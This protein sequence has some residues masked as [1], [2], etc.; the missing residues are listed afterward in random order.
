MQGPDP[1]RPPQP[2]GATDAWPQGG[3]ARDEPRDSTRTI[4]SGTGSGHSGR[5]R[6]AVAT[7]PGAG[8]RLDFFELQRPIGAGGM[9]AVF[10]ALDVRLD[11]FIALK[12]LPP[13]QAVDPEVVQR[14]YQ[15]ARA[16]A[17]L[18]H[19]NIARVYTIGHD[20]SYHFIAFEFIE[21]TTLRDRVERHGPLGITEAIDLTL[22]IAEALMHASD[23]GVVHRDI[24]PSN[25]VVTPQ[26]RAK[27]VDMGLARRFERGGDDGLTQS[28][29]TLG[30]FDYISPEQA[31]DPR[32]VDVRSD[33]YSL[34]CTLFHV[35]TGRPP[36]PEGTVIQKLLQH[37]ADDPPDVRELNPAIPDALAAIIGKLMAKDRDR[38]HQSPEQLSRELL[39]AAGTL[40][41][42]P[43]HP[44]ALAWSTAPAPSRDWQRHL[45]WGLPAVALASIVAALVWWSPDPAPPDGSFD[46]VPSPRPPITVAPAPALT[47]A[48]PPVAVVEP[49]AAPREI[50]L[51]ARD[52]LAE[53]L[54]T[55]PSGS[56]L[57]L[58]EEA[59]YD[60]RPAPAGAP[61]V[62]AVP[63]GRRDLTIKAGPGVRPV[64]RSSGGRPALLDFGPGRVQVEGLAFAP[65]PGDHGEPVAALRARDTDLALTRCT[66]TR[67]LPSGTAPK[68]GAASPIALDLRAA[69]LVPVA[70]DPV[71][72]VRAVACAF[73][74]GQVGVSARG[75]VRASFLDCSFAGADPAFA[76]ASAATKPG[77]SP[78]PAELD[79]SF[80]T[81][82]AGG[83]PAFRFSGVAPIVKVDNSALAPAGAA[84]GTLVAAD[85]PGRLDWWGRHNL[86]GRFATYLQPARDVPGGAPP[87]RDFETWSNDPAGPRESGSLATLD[88][89]WAEAEPLPG[90]DAKDLTPALRLA[91]LDR[92]D[93]PPGARVGP[94]G[95]IAPPGT[96][97]SPAAPAQAEAVA[98]AIPPRE[99]SGRPASVRRTGADH[100][101]DDPLV[102]WKDAMPRAGEPAAAGRVPAAGVA[103]APAPAPTA[104]APA[105]T[106]T[107]RTASQFQEAVERLAASRGGKIRL[108]AGAD[109]ELPPTDLP[110]GSW[111][112]EAEPGPK[113]PR[114]RLLPRPTPADAP[115]PATWTALLRLRSGSLRLRGIDL[116]SGRDDP[117][118]AGRHAALA[119]AAG[120]DV[121]LFDCTATALGDPAR[122]AM[123]V[124][125]PANDEPDGL[126]VP[127]ATVRVTRS[128]LRGDGDLFD[129][130]AGRRLDLEVEDVALGAR[131]SLVHAHGLPRG[132]APA[133]LKLVLRH[134][135]A[136]L[137]GG[138]VR[139][140]STPAEPDLPVAEIIAWDSILATGTADEPL[141]RVEGQGTLD[142]LHDRVHWDG[143]SVAYHQLR[144][145]RRDQT[146]QLGELVERYDRQAWEVVGSDDMPTH[147]DIKFAHPWAP[148]SSPATLT[149]DD[150]LLDPAS[151]LYPSTGVNPSH[152]P[153]AP[154]S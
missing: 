31:R 132:H 9:G 142:E 67:R 38:R 1:S 113:R 136:R 146:Q 61:A 106:D 97:R 13:E 103:V 74:P 6:A 28:G 123:A 51:R 89:I 134:A 98:G 35:L 112:I 118:E 83:G 78:A 117:D 72:L 60:L 147:G 56:T 36:F 41:L 122:T 54:A 102:P 137:L 48:P 128:L 115:A 26:G 153:V 10:L 50:N 105:S 25:I 59:D 64:L 109:L 138:L 3:E 66:F 47:P 4:R 11:R 88:P 39:A 131:G 46:V 100:E 124:V 12:V 5:P 130:A 120:T 63:A 44:E 110:P 69:A 141:V 144:V 20:A 43:E 77:T 119:V 30:T 29:M 76:T 75:P 94:D 107:V 16:A 91:S 129:V 40:G 32:D 8:D 95:P 93:R 114:L 62:A 53:A 37:Q 27:L 133:P 148:D 49:P 96:R 23:R 116:I 125:P 150:L 65:E 111:V 121:E 57:T 55:A 21:G 127:A 2:P 90:P 152:L 143:H 104:S 71:P 42:R 24:K 140:E 22:Q 52:D 151:P 68:A 86:Y 108:A 99:A 82:L 84:L 18:D 7:L 145:Y 92:P 58:V 33:L 154:S 73:G 101:P 17:R 87:I 81:I 149:R 45:F 14:F 139:L 19:E 135:T 85:A 34:G 79:L 15:E 80:V 126:A 70:G